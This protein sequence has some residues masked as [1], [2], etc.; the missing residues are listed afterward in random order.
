MRSLLGDL[1]YAA[2]QI[3]HSPGFAATVILTLALCIG[4]NTAIFTVVDALF[5]RPLPY[6]H[7]DRLVM[8]VGAITHE[9][10]SDL[11]MGQNGKEW[12]LAQKSTLIEPA[13]YGSTSGVNLFVAGHSQYVQQQRIGAGFFH[14]LGAAPLIGHEFTRQ[15]EVQGGPAVAILSYGLW[16]HVFHGNPSIV[17]RT[18]DLKGAPYTVI[19]IMPRGFRTV[20]GQADLWTPLRPSTHGAGGGTNY[21]IVARLKPGVTRTTASAQLTAIMQPYFQSLLGKRAAQFQAE[22]RA[23]PLQAGLT[24]DLRS[25]VDLI[26]GAVILV[27]L[28]GCVNIAGILLARSELRSR[29]IAT[30]IALGASRRRVV[31]QLLTESVFLAFCGG[32]LGLFF[33]D[34]ALAGLLRLNPDEFAGWGAIQLDP[35]VMGIMLAVAIGT[36]IIFGLLPALEATRIDIRS[37]LSQAGR[38]VARGRHWKREMLVFAEVALG[39]VLVVSAGLLIRSF[40]RLMDMNPGFN[41]NHLTTASLSLQDARYQTSQ[42]GARL[43]RDSLRRI[44]KIPGVESAAAT[45]TA[46]YQRALNLGVKTPDTRSDQIT[47]FSYVTPGFFKTLDAPMLRGRAFTEA[48]DANGAKVAIVNKDFIRRYLQNEP[49][50]IGVL[51]QVAGASYQIV[52]IV[53]NMPYGQGWGARYGPIAPLAHVYVPVSQC[54]SRIFS[55]ANVFLSPSFIVRTHGDISGLDMAMQ[56]AIQSVDPRLPFSS[57]HTISQ[58]RGEALHQQRYQTVLF[59]AFACL[60]LLLAALGVFGLV[61]ESVAQRT[62]EMGIR[63]ALGASV[64]KLIVTAARPAIVLSLAGIAAGFVLAV[65]AVRLLTSMI[66]GIPA[67]DP[68]TFASVA[69]LLIVVAALASILPALRLARLDPAQTLRHE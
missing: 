31:S 4:V 38:S 20:D 1:R 18:I 16:Q 51:I 26:W 19:G 48:D 5:F 68:L 54:D 27:L 3:R 49:N 28:I 13:V 39:V 15:E 63:M 56:H 65:F 52:G 9:G 44:R 8:L 7:P 24:H 17:G 62:R 45:L 43:F 2:R 55:L 59:A 25:S 22:E 46:P 40:A 60:A 35:H 67:L 34:L 50:P 36:S 11:Q 37:A 69:A 42:A 21:D 61:S 33:G 47:N 12:E 66:W 57:F 64:R 29:E 41:P 53:A 58:L 10:K 32:L 14:V 23:L 6:P 30:R